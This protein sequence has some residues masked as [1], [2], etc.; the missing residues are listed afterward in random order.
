MSNMLVIFPVGWISLIITRFRW[1]GPVPKNVLGLCS[2]MHLNSFF[3]LGLYG[4]RVNRVPGTHG[5]PF[6]VRLVCRGSIKGE[7]WSERPSHTMPKVT[8]FEIRD[9]SVRGDS[10]DAASVGG[11][12][13]SREEVQRECPEAYEAWISHL[14]L[15]QSSRKDHPTLSVKGKTFDDYVDMKFFRTHATKDITS[16]ALGVLFPPLSP[17]TIQYEGSALG[18]TPGLAF[19]TG[20]GPFSH[21]LSWTGVVKDKT[22]APTGY[23]DLMDWHGCQMGRWTAFDKKS[24]G[25]KDV[26]P[27]PV[28]SNEP[29]GEV[30][31]SYRRPKGAG[32]GTEII[33]VAM[34]VGKMCIMCQTVATPETFRD[35]KVCS[36]CK[37]STGVSV[38]YCSSKCQL[39]DYPRHRKICKDA[40]VVA[41]FKARYIEAAEKGESWAECQNCG[42]KPTW[43][44]VHLFHRCARCMRSGGHVVLYCKAECQRAHYPDHQVV[45]T[46]RLID[47][48]KGPFLSEV[49]DELDRVHERAPTMYAR[50]G[51]DELHG[52]LSRLMVDAGLAPE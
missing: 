6:F 5:I 21:Y 37:L 26:A 14:K 15:L 32:P 51:C 3:V 49:L 48:G 4:P 2:D 29:N 52:E 17:C 39:E 24:Y 35:F 9:L 7:D 11:Y 33:G 16:V 19:V 20:S 18:M 10:K 12:I 38:Y 41:E 23:P 1:Q 31:V 22:C 36:R 30:L 50:M 8:R 13:M 28:F 42:T 34:S 45:C 46:T 44:N 25:F 43:E 40:E 27:L 47:A